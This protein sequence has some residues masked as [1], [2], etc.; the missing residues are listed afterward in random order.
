MAF[1]P[2]ADGALADEYFLNDVHAGSGSFF[3]DIQPA[4]LAL[5]DSHRDNR[6]LGDRHLLEFALYRVDV[7]AVKGAAGRFPFRLFGKS[8]V[9]V[10]VAERTSIL[11]SFGGDRA[12]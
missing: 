7:F 9:F 11:A 8:D 10:A 12:H 3:F 2:A 1:S 5:A 6:L 4:R